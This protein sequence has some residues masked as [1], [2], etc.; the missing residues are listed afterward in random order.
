MLTESSDQGATSLSE[1][2]FFAQCTTVSTD[3]TT[4]SFWTAFITTY[5]E[6][7]CKLWFG[8]PVQ[9]WTVTPSTCSFIPISAIKSRV[10]YSKSKVNFGSIIGE[11]IVYVVVPLESN[12]M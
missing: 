8:Y 10:S 6:H 7:Q 12:T 2:L 5:M 1:I 3:G 9:V 4:T 11:E